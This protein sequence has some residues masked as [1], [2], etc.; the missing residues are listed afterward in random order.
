M[1]LV[2][3]AG[4]H[5]GA[6]EG[7]RLRCVLD[8]VYKDVSEGSA[9]NLEPVRKLVAALVA[10]SGR[11]T[12]HGTGPPTLGKH[13]CARGAA[14]CPMCRY[15][16]PHNPPWPSRR[17]RRRMF[18][19]RG[20]REGSWFGRFPRNDRLVCSYEEHFLLGNMGNLDWRPILNLWAVVEYISQCAMKVPQGSKRLGKVLKVAVDEVCK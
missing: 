5:L 10:S 20:D 3:G 15:G 2:A 7:V 14:E 11:H 9:V 12:L 19:E 13:A 17:G 4:M 8:Q 6:P 1:E 16:F 18:L